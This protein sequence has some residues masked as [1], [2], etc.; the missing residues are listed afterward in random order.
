MRELNNTDTLNEGSIS[1]SI[2]WGCLEIST[3]VVSACIPSLMP[4]ILSFFGKTRRSKKSDLSDRLKEENQ[5]K[6]N[7]KEEKSK[8]GRLTDLLNLSRAEPLPEAMDSS[9]ISRA[10]PDETDNL[11]LVEAGKRS[12][13]GI[14]VTDRIDQV[15]EVRTGEAEDASTHN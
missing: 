12:L 1:T 8:S 7:R 10:V 6:K 9:M 4:L 15:N 5:A 13:S 14:V 11:G 3:Q 2:L